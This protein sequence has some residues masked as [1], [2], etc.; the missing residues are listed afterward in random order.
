ME[1]K[2]MK[3]EAISIIENTHQLVNGNLDI[4]VTLEEYSLLRDLAEDV[5]QI[6]STFSAYIN[7]IAHVL[8]HLSAGNMA[9]SFTKDIE[10]Q[11]DFLP[12][13]NALHK[14]RHSL[15]SSFEEIN[16]LSYEVDKL[17]TQ[18]ET[19][20]TQ[21]AK[22]ASDQADLITDLTNTIYQIT[23]QTSNNATNAKLAAKSVNN[24]QKEA[25]DGRTYMDQML[26]SIQE[27]KSSSHDISHIVDIISGIAGQTKL[28]ALNA[29]I[30]AARAGDAGLGFSVVAQE[31]GLLAEK[32]AEA[33]KKTSE[34]INNSIL[35]AESSAQVAEKTGESFV[36]I[37]TSIEGV[38]KLCTD[39]AE[40]SEIQA[41]SLKS[42]STII[43][44]ISE[45]VQNNAAY[46]QE[47][48]AG[49]TKLV[50]LSAQLKKVMTKFRL[51]NQ[52]SNSVSESNGIKAVEEELLQHLFIRL[53]KAYERNEIDGILEEVIQKQKDFECLYV[54][55]SKGVQLSH[56]IM[57]P[58]IMVEQD[59]N[60]KPAM[61]GDYHGEKKYFR[62]AI[63]NRKECYTSQE[64]IS[65]ATGG[66][67]KTISC[68]YEGIGNQI[69]VLCIDQISKF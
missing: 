26:N 11:G 20:A 3:E 52:S 45:V 36:S 29:A 27:V 28:L 42:T 14:I 31:V 38:T 13:K 6:S 9:V 10:Y 51:M 53:H 48:N 40:I 56:T 47:N 32:S 15:N 1:I 16:L 22:N 54:I 61:P 44:D 25:M 19:G 12:I 35:T 5:N 23:E 58:D 46:A 24:I 2:I 63:K 64:Y 65:T 34:L 59:D 17:C 7:E 50:E 30:E 68:S 37:Q 66:L 67:C 18:V 33:V 8:S 62:E 49:A 4:K 55:D 21:I 69:Y 39:I 60:F 41:Q 57:N 43:T